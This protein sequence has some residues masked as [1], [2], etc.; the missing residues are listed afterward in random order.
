[1]DGLP[2]C[3]AGKERKASRR[4]HRASSIPPALG[5]VVS[6][7]HMRHDDFRPRHAGF[8]SLVSLKKQEAPLFLP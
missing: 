4:T 3:L 7:D 1:M 8:T 5:V 6:L 2:S